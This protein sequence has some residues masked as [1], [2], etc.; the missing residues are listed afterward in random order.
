MTPRNKWVPRLFAG[1]G[2]K[3]MEAVVLQVVRKKGPLP[4]WE[5]ISNAAV[6]MGGPP[7]P[8]VTSS[9]IRAQQAARAAFERLH[10]AGLIQR[11]GL[12]QWTAKV[13]A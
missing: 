3:D 1:L 6:R 10:K 9:L 5:A 2:Y 11:Q 8:Y 12:G 13:T 4:K 7:Y